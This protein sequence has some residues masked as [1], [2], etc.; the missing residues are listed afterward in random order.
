MGAGWGL[1]AAALLALAPPSPARA[2]AASYLVDPE[3]TAGNFSI[4]HFFSRVPGRFTRFEGA[5]VADPQNLTAGS[6]T[7]SID[8]SSIDTNEAAR[9]RHLRSDAFFDV[10]NHPRITFVSRKVSRAGEGKLKVEGDLTIRGI[11]RRA[12]LDVEVLGFGT[13]Y[14]VDRAAFEV[15]TKINRHDF[16][17]SWND[18]VEGGGYILGDEVEIVINLQAKKAKPA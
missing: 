1:V 12:T 8:A 10:E 4:R 17:V 11:T 3:H 18:V 9:D 7:F 2:E 13:L 6:V 16:K 14:G 5:V 15:R